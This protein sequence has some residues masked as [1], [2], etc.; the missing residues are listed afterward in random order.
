MLRS[1]KKTG[2]RT[3]DGNDG[4]WVME[5]KSRQRQLAGSQFP[6]PPRRAA[7]VHLSIDSRGATAVLFFP[8]RQPRIGSEKF[9]GAVLPHNLD[10]SRRVFDEVSHIGEEL[11]IARA[12][13][14]GHQVAAETCILYSHDNDWVLQSQTSRTNISACANTFN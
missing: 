6:R 9:H 8:W 14:Q 2:I 1:L 11:K 7:D 5:P 13:A 10:G 4:F 3:P 12:R